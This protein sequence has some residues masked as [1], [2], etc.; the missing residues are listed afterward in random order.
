MARPRTVLSPALPQAP[1]ASR[2]PAST[3]P[4]SSP[5]RPRTGRAFRCRPLWPDPLWPIS[6]TDSLEAAEARHADLGWEGI[7]STVEWL[8][9]SVYSPEHT[10]HRETMWATLGMEP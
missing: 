10:E 2:K 7:E 6:Y 5:W 9:R 4:E 3:S 1:R 8:N